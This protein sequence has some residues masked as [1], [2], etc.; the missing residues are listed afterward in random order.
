[1]S[2]IQKETPASGHFF[3]QRLIIIISVVTLI[4]IGLISI[5]S[6]TQS[7]DAGS[8]K[9]LERQ[10]IWLG[11]AV[12]AG[13]FVSFVDLDGLK[14]LIPLAGFI[15]VVLLFLVLIPTIGHWV[16]GSRRWIT[17][18]V[19]G[20]QPAEFA[21]IPF[22]FLLAYY[23]SA[24]Q[25]YLKTL[26]RGF[27]VPLAFIAVF[28]LLIILEPDF[29]TCALYGAVGMMLL[30]LAGTRLTYL[31][32]SVISG[33]TLF[34]YLI[35]Q[36][37]VRLSRLLS[38]L[39]VEGNKYKGAYQLH[40]GQMAFG[41]GGVMGVGAGDGRFQNYYLPEAHTDFIYSIIGEEFGFMVTCLILVLFLVI[42][43]TVILSLRRAPNLFQGLIV[44]GSIFMIAMQALI[45]MG[46]VTGLL[47]TK[48]ISLPFISYGGSNLVVMCV[49]TGVL[50][51]CLRSWEH[52]PIRSERRKLVEI[53]G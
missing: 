14:R 15:A 30:Y 37:P 3:Y 13:V 35:F 1:M 48:G 53:A 8:Y 49:F 38:F 45:N 25:R 32:P 46:V 9:F 39:D 2:K 24:N 41:N 7:L 28:C 44:L 42:F 5:F 43:C 26:L 20:F 40:Q 52:L 29:G 6:A 34:L 36:D 18:G 33:G 31:I 17:F 19:I 23:L 12:V 47:P 21:K 22:I 50:I 11:I 10:I 16:N 51:N 27:L 4:L